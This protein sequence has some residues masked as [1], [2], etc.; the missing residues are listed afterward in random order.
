MKLYSE[1]EL[2][3]AVESHLIEKMPN[4]IL[5]VNF[6]LLNKKMFYSN[7]CIISYRKNEKVYQLYTL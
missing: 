4:R 1:I 6:V 3:L 7:S 5:S 2:I